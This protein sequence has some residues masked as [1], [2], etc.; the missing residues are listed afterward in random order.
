MSKN[1]LLRG[2]PDEMVKEIDRYAKAN[3]GT[4]G[5]ASRDRAIQGLLRRALDDARA[6]PGV[7]RGDCASTI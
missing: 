6:T 7:V 5:K 3:A 4:A 2:V 1:V